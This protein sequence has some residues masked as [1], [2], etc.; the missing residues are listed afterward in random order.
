LINLENIS[1]KYESEYALENLEFK[2][3]EGEKIVLLGNNGSGKSTLLKILAGLI[4][5]SSGKYFYK[6][7]LVDKSFVKKRVKEFRKDVAILFQDPDTLLFNATVY[8]E[9]AFGIKQLGLDVDVKEIAKRFEIEHLLDKNPLKLS[10]GEKQKVAFCAIFAT[11]PTLLL[12]DEPTANLDPKT[13]GWFIDFLYNLDVT[14]IISTH[15]LSLAYELGNRAIVIDESHSIIYDGDIKA[16]FQN[17]QILLKANLMHKHK[18][19]HS[20]VFHSHFH[21]HDWS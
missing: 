9:V 7:N 11:N 12:L 13:T 2:A 20:D 8:E 16:L 14:T 3:K 17:E 21:I 1:Y 5:P 6:E 15:N 10:G 19:K 4:F 18:H